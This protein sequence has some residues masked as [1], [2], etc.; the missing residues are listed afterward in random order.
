MM[1]P[2]DSNAGPFCKSSGVGRQSRFLQ[3]GGQ[4]FRDRLKL[5]YAERT[6]EL[7]ISH[8]EPQPKTKPK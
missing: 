1:N 6:S 8:L 5:E 4:G 7:H 2:L 3:E